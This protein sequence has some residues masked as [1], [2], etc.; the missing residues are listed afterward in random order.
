MRNRIQVLVPALI[1]I[2]LLGLMGY[3]LA[4]FFVSLIIGAMICVV[5]YPFYVRFVSWRFPHSVAAITVI[6]AFCL[7]LLVP[8]GLAM[9]KGAQ[10]T[11]KVLDVKIAEFSSAKGAEA[12]GH[13]MEKLND[14]AERISD[15]W[16]FDIPDPTKLAVD[17]GKTAGRWAL[18]ALKNLL[19]QIPELLLGFFV[20]LMIVYFGLVEASTI[21]VWVCKMSFLSPNHH[22]KII[23]ILHSNLKSVFYSN[24]FT[25]IVQALIVGVA[26][27]ITNTADPFVIGFITFICSFIPVIGAAPVAFLM[28]GIEVYQAEYTDAFILL[29]MGLFAGVIDNFLRPIILSGGTEIH[30]LIGFL[31]IIG[32]IYVFGLPGLFLGP[33]M[34]SVATSLIPVYADEIRDKWNSPR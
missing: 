32:G 26:T 10:A 11:L 6:T 5:L 34:V 29:G 7:M 16:G 25:G 14:N 23:S 2:F 12:S 13:L 8:L 27:T 17:F 15:E 31:A 9:T 19:A 24:V 3:I 21:R 1:I 28:A 30:P 22:L 33:L 18:G 20:I 4:P